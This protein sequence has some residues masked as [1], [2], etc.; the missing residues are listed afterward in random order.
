MKMDIH[1]AGID[2]STER[3]KVMVL[4]NERTKHHMK[5]FLN[6]P[7]A[8]NSAMVVSVNKQADGADKW[9]IRLRAY[10]PPK[11]ILVAQARANKLEH[12]VE[13]ASENLLKKIDGHIARVRR[14]ESSKRRSRQSRLEKLKMQQDALSAD[15]VDDAKSIIDR[16]LPKLNFAARREL[17]FLRSQGDLPPNYPT[18]QDVVDE[19][20]AAVIADWKTG[21]DSRAAYLCMLEKLHGVLEKEVKASTIF[22]EMVPLEGPAPLDPEDQAESM[23]GE[24]FYEFWQPD[25]QLRFEDLIA[26]NTSEI[27]PAR[28]RDDQKAEYT[29]R[30]LKDLP[31]AWRR[32]L[33]LHELED[34]AEEELTRI[35]GVD[36]PTVAARISQ[37]DHYIRARL[38]EAGF[39]AQTGSLLSDFRNGGGEPV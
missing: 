10:L 17:M 11:A 28:I 4:I 13:A 26:D 9:E 15:S 6:N 36:R 30:L 1:L 33:M 21:M 12:A 3:D 29:L 25:E 24:E 31:I 23:V 32:A 35:L 34:I 27:P 14:Q 39:E 20:V 5:S 38:T 16:L 8:S 19:V 37:A 2:S 22:G 7:G 18:V